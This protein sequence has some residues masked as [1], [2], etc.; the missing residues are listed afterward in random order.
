MNVFGVKFREYINK[1]NLLKHNQLL[2]LMEFKSWAVHLN[3]TNFSK[4]NYTLHTLRSELKLSLK[5]NGEYY[6]GISNTKRYSVGVHTNTLKSCIEIVLCK[7]NNVSANPDGI[8]SWMDVFSA[9]ELEKLLFFFLYEYLVVSNF[10]SYNVR[11]DLKFSY[12]IISSDDNKDWIA[13]VVENKLNLP[14]V[15]SYKYGK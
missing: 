8:Y 10:N 11:R 4:A 9:D 1:Y 5:N 13:V 15:L 14:L 2:S 7:D 3:S 6:G 12:N